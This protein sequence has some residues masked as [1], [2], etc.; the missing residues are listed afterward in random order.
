[1]ALPKST[2]P[3]VWWFR[4]NCVTPCISSLELASF[5]ERKG[6]SIVIEPEAK[7][8]GLYWKNGIPQFDTGPLP[9]GHENWV[10]EA[11]EERADE[12]FDR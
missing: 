4:R 2:K 1:M 8:R 12:L 3:D 6:G 11:R 10:E 5:C 7:P 9:P